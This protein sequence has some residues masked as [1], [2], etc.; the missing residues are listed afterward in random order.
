M[1]KLT[2]GLLTVVFLLTLPVRAQTTSSDDINEA[3]KAVNAHMEKDEAIESEIAM[4]T[5][6]P[7]GDASSAPADVVEEQSTELNM[8][9]PID[10]IE[11]LRIVQHALLR[12]RNNDY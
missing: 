9:P 10:H 8:P 7:E 1:I 6:A 4:L 2:T 3:L 5:A 12:I 11:P